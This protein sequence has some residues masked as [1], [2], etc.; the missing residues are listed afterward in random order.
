MIGMPKIRMKQKLTIALGESGAVAIVIALT[1]AVLC[2]FVA[3]AVDIGHLLMVKAEL[4]RTAD[5][6][7][8]AGVAG[9]V[10]YTGSVSDPTPYWANGVTQA[11]KII[12]EAANQ[13]DNLIFNDTDGVVVYGYWLLSP[14][15][16]YVQTLPT[17]RPTTAAYR[18]E[19]A[20]SVT[21]NRDVTLYFAPLIGVYWPKNSEC[22]SNRNS[23]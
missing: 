14:P 16:G 18:P 20:I 15:T 1:F 2:G 23:P 8:L 4:Q 11:H 7:V 12:S 5:A 6:A 21:L 3:L 17:A 22:H 13:A 9:L 19:P 10:P